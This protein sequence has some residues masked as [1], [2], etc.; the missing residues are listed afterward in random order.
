MSTVVRLVTL[1]GLPTDLA[2]DPEPV[3]GVGTSDWVVPVV[4][5]AAVLIVLAATAAVVLVWRRGR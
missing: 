5:A 4:I 1:L 2:P 3:T